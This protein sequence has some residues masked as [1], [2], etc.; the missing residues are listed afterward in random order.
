MMEI[1]RIKATK[2]ALCKLVRD[3]ITSERNMDSG[4]FMLPPP[5]GEN[6][7]FEKLRGSRTYFLY[8]PCHSAYFSTGWGYGYLSIKAYGL[9]IERRI[10]L[11][12]LRNRGMI[13]KVER[14]I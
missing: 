1:E 9:E 14:N 11:E 8:W 6:T 3:T 5:R 4:I 7:C 13:E 10:S 12:E 2:T